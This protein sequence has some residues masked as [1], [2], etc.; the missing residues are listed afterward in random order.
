MEDKW[1]AKPALVCYF[2][3]VGGIFMGS[4]IL[5]LI[6][7]GIGIEY[8][9]SPFPITLI[10]TPVNEFI[11][12]GVTLLFARYKS[13]SFKELGLKKVSFRILAI[14]SVLAVLLYFVGLI[15]FV[16]EEIVFGSDPTSELYAKLVMPSDS[17]QL[18]V[19]IGFHLVLVGPCEELAFRGFVQKGFE[20]S[21]GKMKG[22]LI[23]SVLFG[24]LHGFNTLYVIFP[25]F[26]GGLLLGYVW[27]QT[28]GNTTASAMM[29]GVN[30]AV[31]ITI[32][33][34]LTA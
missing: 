3:L 8:P 2:A 26:V 12:L 17:F 19:M 20:N 16:G 24:L 31:S 29:H 18:V 22:L 6:L 34:F 27:Q 33:Y 11:I 14:V 9:D 1:R 30:N 25:T 5:R 4:I 32:A 21:F 28:G 23:A 15:V 7:L 10:A 13:A